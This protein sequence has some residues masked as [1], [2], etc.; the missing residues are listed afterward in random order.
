MPT[1]AKTYITV[2]G[3]CWDS[4]AKKLWGE[5]R[6]MHYLLDANPEYREIL[7]FA[8]NVTLKVPEDV[9]SPEYDMSEVLPPWRR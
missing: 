8:A 9:Q 3:D 2:S 1:E 4:I 6:Y 5:E 7:I